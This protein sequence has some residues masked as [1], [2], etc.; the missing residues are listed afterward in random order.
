MLPFP[1][2]WYGFPF[3]A[4]KKGRPFCPLAAGRL[5]LKT[6][7][8]IQSF[9]LETIFAAF[10]LLCVI[11]IIKQIKINKKTQTDPPRWLKRGPGPLKRK[12][13]RS[14][15][16]PRVPSPWFAP[17]ALKSPRKPYSMRPCASLTDFERCLG[18]GGELVTVQG[19]L[20]FFDGFYLVGLC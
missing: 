11:I 13:T 9:I 10:Y 1:F 12:K 20:T 5:K 18:G 15:P 16:Q 17:S 14:V 2:F 7:N 19:P 4:T 8:I 6:N 3:K